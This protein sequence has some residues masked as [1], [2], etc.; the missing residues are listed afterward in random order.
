MR[1]HM[2]TSMF[3][4]IDSPRLVLGS[5]T[6]KA[7]KKLG[8]IRRLV[9]DTA[10]VFLGIIWALGLLLAG[11]LVW[12]LLDRA[13]LE[14]Q[15]AVETVEEYA[16]RSLDIASFVADE[17][18]R[19]LDRQG[20]QGALQEGP[21]LHQELNRLNAYLPAGSATILVGS[22]GTVIA[23]SET[24]APAPVDLSDRQWY[25]AHVDEGLDEY[26]GPAIRSRVLNDVMIYTFTQAYRVGGQ[27]EA[28]INMGIPTSSIIG[29]SDQNAEVQVALVQ[30]EGF[31]VAAQP[32][33]SD[34]IGQI[35]EVPAPQNVN[36]ASM[37]PFFGVWATTAVRD[38]PE[39]EIYALASVPL[40]SGALLP[41]VW[42]LAPAFILL[43]FVSIFATRMM[44]K[45][46]SKGTALEKALDD[47]RVLF[48]EVH[49]RVK[50]N[51]QII[52]SML[53]LQGDKPIEEL[54]PLIDQ[55]IQRIQAIAAVHE[56]V[57]SSDTPSLIALDEYLR[58]LIAQLS[59]SILLD[60]AELELDFAPISVALD[61]AVPVALL[62][63]EAISNAMKYGVK[64]GGGKI[65]IVLRQEDGVN[66][67]EVLDD[68]DGIELDKIP[69][70]LG[71]R[72]MQ[73]LA[74]QLKGSYTLEPR[75]AGGTRFAVTWS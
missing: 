39:R 59:N 66:C 30:Y 11:L 33:R 46:Q 70:G 50:N 38:L 2:G 41:A 49:H 63:T 73:A 23:S 69:A 74:I 20:L 71:T 18:S 19:E 26:I 53:R 51:L 7:A 54:R 56:Q 22:D 17:L 4:M 34:L 48:Q 1:P 72:I 62:A 28:I 42:V 60:G 40:L 36:G 45:I 37:S 31:L 58:R 64:P 68:G 3:K 35:V 24:P 12:A 65:R 8:G 57:Y 32:M 47:N 10:H 13:R 43:I 75:A 44:G 27:I 52:A 55:T 16:L 67:L 21:K 14:A 29:L 9:D 25:R 61:Y 6:V 15:S 5:G